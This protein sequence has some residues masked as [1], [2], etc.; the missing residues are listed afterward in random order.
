MSKLPRSL[1]PAAC[2]FMDHEQRGRRQNARPG[3]D[4][5]QTILSR[6]GWTRASLL[7]AQHHTPWPADLPAVLA[8]LEEGQDLALEKK[9]CQPCVGGLVPSQLCYRVICAKQSLHLFTDVINGN[10]EEQGPRHQPCGSPLDVFLPS[11]E[12][13]ATLSQLYTH[14]II[15][16]FFCPQQAC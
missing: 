12:E 1:L 13:L 14:L 8:E 16:L 15:M 5:G 9:V 11:D 3:L 2:L 4:W 6:G 10:V 7:G